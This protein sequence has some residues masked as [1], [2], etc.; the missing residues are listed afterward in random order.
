MTTSREPLT[1]EQGE[2]KILALQ[3]ELAERDAIIR[4][5]RDRLTD[6]SIRAGDIRLK[7]PHDDA[8]SPQ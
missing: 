6:Y 7:G 3:Q 2:I 1:P 5:L 8:T 4:G